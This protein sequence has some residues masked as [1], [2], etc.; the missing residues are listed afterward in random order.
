MEWDWIFELRTF[1]DFGLFVLIWMVQLIVYPSFYHVC[2][3]TLKSWHKTYTQR[4]SYFVIPLMLSQLLMSLCS[5]FCNMTLLKLIDLML[6]LATWVLTAW[7]SVPLHKKLAAGSQ[8]PAIRIALVRTNLPRTFV[9]TGI[10][11]LG[12]LR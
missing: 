3:Q 2:N 8:E 11:F 6:V 9:W 5:F 12:L 7:L 4:I 1:V 10:F